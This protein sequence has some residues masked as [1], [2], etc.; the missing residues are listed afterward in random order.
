MSTFCIKVDKH[1]IYLFINKD[2][3]QIQYE[4]G[5]KET[6]DCILVFGAK[7]HHTEQSRC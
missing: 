7:I 1:I 6:E 2:A 4:C 5:E 3:L